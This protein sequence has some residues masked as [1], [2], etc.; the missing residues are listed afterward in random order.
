MTG[1]LTGH[2]HTRE[3]IGKW[4]RS[5]LNLERAVPLS[6]FV[7]RRESRAVLEVGMWRNRSEHEGKLRGNSSGRITE[8]AAGR[9]LREQRRETR[10]IVAE[11]SA[12]REG[13]LSS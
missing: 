8:E 3:R 4:L 10:G 2:A 11:E 1:E 6:G 9:L 13:Q 7:C 5:R 12:H